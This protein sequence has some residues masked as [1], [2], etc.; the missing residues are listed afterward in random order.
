[1]RRILARQWGPWCVAALIAVSLAPAQ[2]IGFRPDPDPRAD[3]PAVRAAVAAK[4]KAATEILA[5]CRE[6]LVGPPGERGTPTALE[7][8]EEIQFWSRQLTDAKL[9]AAD[10]RADRIKILAEAFDRAR[11]YE[12]EI[13]DLAGNEASGLTKL[14]AARANF[15]RAEAEAR[16]LRE[17]ARPDLPP[18]AK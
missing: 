14:S 7:S 12:A 9:E 18:A 1:M 16:L 17:K 5:M 11:G 3:D 10:D 13:K 2:P 15:Y 6:F 8:A 4:I